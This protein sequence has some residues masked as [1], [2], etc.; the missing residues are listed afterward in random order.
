MGAATV[1][2]PQGLEI[3]NSFLR[4]YRP[5]RGD[6]CRKTFVINFFQV[7]PYFSLTI[8]AYQLIKYYGQCNNNFMHSS[9]TLLL[10]DS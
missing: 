1:T 5:I 8:S 10:P 3:S 9:L 6:W 2:F 7:E 4:F